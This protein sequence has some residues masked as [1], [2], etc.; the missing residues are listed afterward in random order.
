MSDCA[1]P[2]DALVSG[3]AATVATETVPRPVCQRPDDG[4]LRRV[5]RYWRVLFGG[6]FLK[7]GEY[8]GDSAVYRLFGE[9]EFA[10]DGVDVL[11]DG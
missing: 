7:E 9:F 6:S 2:V 8:C 5:V 11:F 10:E 3:W 4:R 1:V